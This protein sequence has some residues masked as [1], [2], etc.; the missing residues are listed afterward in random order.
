[1]PFS[2]AAN[3]SFN[4]TS[5]RCLERPLRHRGTVSTSFARPSRTAPTCREFR[6]SAWAEAIY[7]HDA[8]WLAR[9]NLLHAFAQNDVSG[10][11]TPTPGYNRLKAE[12]SY[13]TKLDPER[14]VGRAE[15]DDRSRRR[16]SAEREHSQCR[17]LQQGRSAAAGTRRAA[18]CE[19][20][21]LS[22]AFQSCPDCYPC[23][24][25]ALKPHRMS[26]S[27]QRRL[28]PPRPRA[29]SSPAGSCRILRRTRRHQFAD[30]QAR[31]IH[32]TRHVDLP[33]RD[34]LE[35][36]AT[37]IS[38]V[39]DQHHETMPFA[40]AS[41]SAR[42]SSARPIR[43]RG[44]AARPSAARAA[45]PACRRYRPAI[46]GPSRPAACRCGR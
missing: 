5:C 20:E 1:M 31:P 34:H 27:T 25:D 38:F 45:A 40:F 14:L 43:G 26:A 2:A 3:S 19:R 7:Y 24:V 13:T 4:T 29:D 28:S 10:V 42:S 46:A 11:E 21:V 18:V 23:N 33:F 41:P 36:D 32:R 37:V 35:A 39:A 44:T 15:G 30:Q 22:M 6:R 17:L 12:V 16:Q 9:I 8:N